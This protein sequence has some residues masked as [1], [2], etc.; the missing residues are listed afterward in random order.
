MSYILDALKK[1]D[2]ERKRGQV[3]ALSSVHD[4]YPAQPRRRSRLPYVIVAATLLINAGILAVW[5][6]LWKPQAGN[7][8]ITSGGSEQVLSSSSSAELVNREN[9]VLSS[10]QSSEKTV[11]TD[12]R[13]KITEQIPD[14]K[15]HLD[16]KMPLPVSAKNTGETSSL[17]S[18][19]NSE[20]ERPK[21]W[22]ILSLN[23]L[24]QSV[25]EHLPAMSSVAHIYSH[26]PA[27]RMVSID[28]RVVREGQLLNQELKLE[29]IQ[30]DGMIFSYKDYRFHVGL[31]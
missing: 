26:D 17:V 24:P 30:P 25:R 29:E 27:A 21:P 5:L 1:S 31:R 6:Q 23:E 10:G 19:S 14:R 18:Q 15:A 4:A 3:P 13:E 9:I 16:A 2:K 12:R 22:K 8:V 7:P 11:T 28:G 20:T